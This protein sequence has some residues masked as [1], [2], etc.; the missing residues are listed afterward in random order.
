M[1]EDAV[2]VVDAEL[3]NDDHLPAIV[4]PAPNARPTVDRHTILYPGQNLPTEAHQPT[5]TKRNLYVCERTKERLENQSAP[6]N[7]SANYRSQHNQLGVALCRG[8]VSC[9]VHAQS[10]SREFESEVHFRPPGVPLAQ[11]DGR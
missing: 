2:E 11:V 5:Y 8:L 1:T 3:V 6:K 9:G 10:T 7:T 4:A